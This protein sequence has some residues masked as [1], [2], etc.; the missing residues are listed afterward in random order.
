MT[1]YDVPV[2][3][4]GG[5]G[6]T[7]DWIGEAEDATRDQLAEQLRTQREPLEAAGLAVA[8][9]PVRGRPADAILETAERV[10]ADLIVTGSRGRGRLRSM[11]LGSVANE[12]ASRATRPV[13]VARAPSIGRVVVATDGSSSTTSIVGRLEAWG[14]LR[15]HEAEVVAVAVP[16][17]PA[18]E[19]IVSLST[20]GDDRRDSQRRGVRAE[21]EA[22]ADAMAQCLT[23]IGITATPHVRAG[24]PAAEILGAVDDANANLVVTG[25]R[26]LGGI[27]RLLLG[28]VARNVLVHARCSV[29]VVRGTPA[30]AHKEA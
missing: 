29:L 27:D 23:E 3:W 7:M 15:D 8:A 20:L 18:Y 30:P 17:G 6:S 11:L 5:V 13:L 2:D 14:I 16:D 12:V 19:L 26:G 25:S 1:A 22:A 21:A 10:D 4:T 28:S 9:E 24:D